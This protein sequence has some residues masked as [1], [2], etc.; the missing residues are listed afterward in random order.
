MINFH[1]CE[2]I[3]I[4]KPTF[5]RNTKHANTTVNK[6]VSMKVRK[7]V[8]AITKCRNAVRTLGTLDVERNK[9]GV[10]KTI[11]QRVITIWL[12]S[13][14]FKQSSHMKTTD[15]TCDLFKEEL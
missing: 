1:A 2:Y 4:N 11:I 8:E 13:L 14:E 12:T 5:S 6:E 7:Y 9:G 10:Y 15:Y 3:G